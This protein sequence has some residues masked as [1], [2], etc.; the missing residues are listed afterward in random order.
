[1][2][3]QALREKVGD[4]TFFPLLRAWYAKNKY[5]NVTTSD[6][7]ALAERRSGRNL[8]HFFRVWLFKQGRPES[9]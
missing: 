6:F 1:M 9:W 4:A 8:D 5:G 2:T 7:I 3:L